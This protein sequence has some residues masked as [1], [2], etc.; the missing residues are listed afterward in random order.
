M[1]LSLTTFASLPLSLTTL[2]NFYF[3][4]C[5]ADVMLMLLL[6]MGVMGFIPSG[7]LSAA[8]PRA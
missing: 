8:L 3:Y 7:G 6:C 4:D 5:Y 2:L 1:L